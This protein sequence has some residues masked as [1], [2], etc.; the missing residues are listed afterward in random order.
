MSTPLERQEGIGYM[1]DILTAASG[2]NVCSFKVD[3]KIA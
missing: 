3:Q 1:L 2:V